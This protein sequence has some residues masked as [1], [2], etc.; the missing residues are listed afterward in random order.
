MH[1]VRGLEYLAAD[2]LI[3]L[4]TDVHDWLLEVEQSSFFTDKLPIINRSPNDLVALSKRLEALIEEIRKDPPQSIQ[5]LEKLLLHWL[6]QDNSPAPSDASSETQSTGAVA[7]AGTGTKVS[8]SDKILTI[9]LKL[10]KSFEGPVP[11]V[12][13]A[14]LTPLGL[15]SELKDLVALGGSG[16]LNVTA[17]ADAHAVFGFDLTRPALPVAY[18]RD[19]TRAD[20]SAKV[21]ASNLDFE[22]ALGP[23]GLF[24]VNGTARIDDG[25]ARPEDR[26]P[27]TLTVTMDIDETD[28]RHT[29]PE[30]L[31]S[32]NVDLDGYAQT[33]LPL[34]FPTR[35]NLLSPALEFTVADLSHSL[36]TATITG[37][38]LEAFL[39]QLDLLTNL[40]ALRKG[41]D[42]MLG[43]V[44]EL[45]KRNVLG[46]DFPLVGDQLSRTLDFIQ[47]MRQELKGDLGLLPS[48]GAV[49]VQ[50]ALYA[51]LGPNGLNWLQDRPTDSDT[52][53]T[54]ND[55]EILTDGDDY[56]QFNMVLAEDYRLIDADLDFDIGLPGLGLALDGDVAVGGGFRWDLRFGV[57]KTDGVYVDTSASA[58]PELKVTFGATIPDFQ[59]TGQLGFLQVSAKDDRE[60]P[61]TFG[62]TFEV[63]FIS[64][65]AQ[66][67]RL[68][69]R[70]LQ[71]GL[72][73]WEHAIDV[74]LEAKT[75]VNLALLAGFSEIGVL[76]SLE[77]DF[78]LVWNF[79]PEDPDLKGAVPTIAFNDVRLNLGSFFSSFAGPVL[80]RLQEVLRPIQ[81]VI[82]ALNSRVPV[83]SDL[84]G[85]DLNFFQAAQLFGDPSQ[86]H[87]AEFLE[88]VSGIITLINS[89]PVIDED[90]YISL[91]SFNLLGT[92]VRNVV[93]LEKASPNPT[94]TADP[95]SQLTGDA[96][97]FH[98]RTQNVGGKAMSFPLLENPIQAFRLLLGQDIDLF[99]YDM[100][101][102]ELSLQHAWYFPVAPLTYVEL[103]GG[104]GAR[105]D[106]AFGYDTS[107]LREFAR[108]G[109][110]SDVFDGFFVSDR[111]SPDGSGADVPEVQFWAN[112]YAALEVSVAGLLEAG[113]EGGITASVFLDLK[114]YDNDGKVHAEEF[115]QTLDDDLISTFDVSGAL[116]AYLKAYVRA[117]SL[118]WETDIARITLA[119]FRSPPD[120]PI[121]DGGGDGT[122]WSDARNW[123]GDKLP[124][125]SDNVIVNQPYEDITVVV[126]DDVA[127]ASIRSKERILV[128]A[129]VLD[130]PAVDARHVIVGNEGQLVT[131]EVY[132]GERVDVLAGGSATISDDGAVYVS[133]MDVQSRGTLW[134]N[135]TATFNRLHVAS[136]GLVSHAAGDT[137][138]DLRITDGMTVDAGGA[139]SVD[140]RG[141]AGASGPGAGQ[142]YGA[143]QGSAYAGGGAHG[144]GGGDATVAGGT[145]YGSLLQPAELG[146]GGGTA[147]WNSGG[148]AGR[149]YEYG[150]AGGGIV[151]LDVGGALKVDGVISAN[152]LVGEYGSAYWGS[153]WTGGGGAGGSIDITV[154]WL[155]GAGAITAN[156][157]SAGSAG[158]G[159]GGGGGR[160]ALE[161]GSVEFSGSIST[162]GGAGARAGALDGVSE[163]VGAALRRVDC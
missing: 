131:R 151:R 155:G 26:K 41:W 34:S 123:Q 137:N 87:F 65:L 48:F 140:G 142:S 120:N 13:A 47:R 100:P 104:I 111:L 73:S 108:T 89:I 44:E 160:I 71:A 152:G 76:P 107:G 29:I 117:V 69:L 68:K 27:A 17:T 95:V 50:E 122:S 74:S 101:A 126:A 18:I 64:P 49:A 129:G 130:C 23:L 45:L 56:V 40:E 141:H 113:I 103:G 46:A 30:A 128:Q 97:T 35:D 147:S 154:G 10:N 3:Q 5:K 55:I 138:F 121:W 11:F 16:Q 67:S 112:I 83:L 77:A 15:P 75:E 70:D 7:A 125:A 156:G 54:A 24:V 110:V 32:F 22:M 90:V 162:F 98:G 116:E 114:D 158:A 39:S 148:S 106:L 60:H 51:G 94:E 84:L 136:A 20:L 124:G 31:S 14:D 135:G 145:G 6:G 161:Y 53:V 12:L 36:S 88:A 61:S 33:A 58:E 150:G 52:L 133:Q 1:P 4:L 134:V 105:L 115:L 144:G 143:G 92:D 78:N 159:G 80:G 157:G 118:K 82:D 79:A 86:V 72:A 102:L 81:P 42:E 9:D 139:V 91:G 38:D 21:E 149:I 59:A 66:T 85:E 96:A 153:S 63:D 163:V 25:A 127:A 57:S 19:D 146:S 109:Y 2:K 93:S 43:L 99:L 28:H 119:D 37:P 8:Y 62:G 132:D